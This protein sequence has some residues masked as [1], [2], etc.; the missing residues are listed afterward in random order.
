MDDI[1]FTVKSTK[2]GVHF[3]PRLGWHNSDVRQDE[4]FIKV[5]LLG[6]SRYNPYYTIFYRLHITTI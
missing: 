4:H 6:E 1:G 3:K 2:K 5:F